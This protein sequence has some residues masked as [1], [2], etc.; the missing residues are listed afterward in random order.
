MAGVK[1]A[2]VVASVRRGLPGRVCLALPSLL[3]LLAGCGGAMTN[4]HNRKSHPAA[5][6]PRRLEVLLGKMERLGIG[7]E[8]YLRTTRVETVE[9]RR[10][11]LFYSGEIGEVSLSAHEGQTFA[12]GGVAT[13]LVR[14]I[15]STAYTYEP[16]LADV[17]G[18]R[19]WVRGG[20]SRNDVSF[21]Y[22]GLAGE[23][24]M[25]GTGSYAGLINLLKTAAVPV[26]I[27]GSETIRGLRTSHFVA[28][29]DPAVLL[30]GVSASQLTPFTRANEDLLI[31]QLHWHS[32]PTRLEVFLTASGLPVRIVSYANVGNRHSKETLDVLATNE[33]LLVRPPSARETL[34]AK[35]FRRLWFSGAFRR[36]ER[37]AVGG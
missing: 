1:A 16:Q 25:G 4:A 19:R 6:L 12:A 24:S 20:V 21:P 28:R 18:G 2:S 7:S 31:V 35:Q 10:R 34:S 23:R 9:R 15:G 27:A 5:V 26:R 36:S 14:V 33:P 11:S 17:P 8:R 3:L 30:R 37:P 29:V 32:L 22:H 13:P